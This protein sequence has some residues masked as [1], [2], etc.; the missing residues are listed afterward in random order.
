MSRWGRGGIRA[1][2][3]ALLAGA[4]IA[5]VPGMLDSRAFADTTTTAGPTTAPSSTL[6]PDTTSTTTSAPAAAV[7]HAANPG[8]KIGPPA[9]NFGKRRAGTV[10]FTA[11]SVVKNV[12]QSEVTIDDINFTRG[13][14]NDFVVGTTCFP[15]G[16]PATLEP[17]Q[18]C[19]IEVKFVP[20]TAGVRSVKVRVVDDAPTSRKC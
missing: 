4:L 12:S 9:L 5:G 11:T 14:A 3:C 20:R 7:S 2:C 6:V 16:K 10:S 1:G 15:G 19:F 13:N 17:G 8:I 18:V